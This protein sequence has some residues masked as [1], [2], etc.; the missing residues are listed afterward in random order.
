MRRR[1]GFAAVAIIFLL[2]ACSDTASSTPVAKAHSTPLPSG[3]T[4]KCTDRY[5]STWT[6]GPVE[7]GQYVHY[8]CQDGKVTSWWVDGNGGMENSPPR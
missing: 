2:V 8:V 7:D 4:L 6:M 1:P 5:Q 3:L